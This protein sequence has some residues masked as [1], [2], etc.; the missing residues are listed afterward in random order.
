MFYECRVRDTVRVPPNRFEKDLNKVILELVQKDYEGLV[1]TD[2]GV[3]VAVTS[4]KKAGEGKVI[5]GDGAA[6]YSVEMNLLAYKPSVQELVEGFVSEV[7]EFGAFVKIGPVEGLI[8]VSQI[9]DDYI[10]HDAK[11]PGFVGRDSRRALK[12]NDNVLARV[13][14]VS[15]KSTVAESKIGLTMR[16]PGLGKKEWAKIK[17]IAVAD[18]K[19]KKERQKEAKAEAKE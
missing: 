11:L 19:S 5:P 13:V 3:V 6:Y 14:S 17:T 16:Q 2:M 18:G 4:A 10:N 9:M 12:L 8:H 7:A 15:M 1:D